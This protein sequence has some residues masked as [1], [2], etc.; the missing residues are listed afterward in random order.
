MLQIL[1]SDSEKA[2]VGVFVAAWNIAKV[3]SLAL[4]QITTVM[5]PS[6]SK[7]LAR[8]NEPLA[9]HYLHQALRFGLILNLPVCVVLTTQP[10][11][12]M[13]WV[14]SR[15]F[16]GGGTVLCLLVIGEALR[17][18]HAILGTTLE[19]AGE[20]RT[21]A[22]VTVASFVPYIAVLLLFIPRWG[23]TGAA[24]SSAAVVAVC[25]IVF[26]V[27]IW[28]RFGALMNT[29]SACNIALAGCLMLL[30]FILLSKID[31][32]FVLPYAASLIA[33]VGCLIIS[34]EITQEDF[35]TFVPG[36]RAKATS[37]PNR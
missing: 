2:A 14:Y 6:I 23:T 35:A 26:G 12:L 7:A 19:A 13:Q 15:D 4:T 25:V 28:Q 10:D 9:R 20:A 34:R 1:S 32:W 16:S 30:V 37:V 21:A 31:I 3:P 29:R 8:R 27:I 33:Y 36:M 17:V 11:A 5:L 22:V 24:A 18:F